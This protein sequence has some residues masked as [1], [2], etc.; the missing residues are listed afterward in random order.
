[1]LQTD[2]ETMSLGES[3]AEA[4]TI[5]GTISTVASVVVN[6]LVSTI[7][8]GYL[9]TLLQQ[10]G[11]ASVVEVVACQVHI[12]VQQGP[13]S[14]YAAHPGSRDSVV[15]APAATSAAHS[16]SATSHRP[17]HT[18]GHIVEPSVV[19]VVSVEYYADLALV[20]KTA[21]HSRSLTSPVSVPA[22][23]QVVSSSRRNISEPAFHHSRTQGK[24]NHGLLLTVV[25]ACELSLVRLLLNHLH[26]LHYLRGDVLGRQLRVVE[27]EGLAVDGDFG[28]GLPVYSHA[29]VRT[30]FHSREF[31]EQ[32]F[33]H[34]VLCGPE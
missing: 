3:I 31:L 20:G 19:G 16:A 27:E 17:H 28:N 7:K 4:I 33:K 22:L 18:P 5:A 1:M 21:Y 9:V 14:V 24:V 2:S 11:G 34:I 8:V 29:A 12:P 32:V 10:F 23:L 15:L 30:H 25:N 6:Q 26:F 13:R